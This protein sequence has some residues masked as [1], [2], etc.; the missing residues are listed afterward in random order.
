MT[1]SI[2]I[3]A[4]IR[5]SNRLSSSESSHLLNKTPPPPPPLSLSLSLS[6]LLSIVSP[7]SYPPYSTIYTTPPLV[8]LLLIDSS[9]SSPGGDSDTPSYQSS[10][11][12]YWYSTVPHLLPLYLIRSVGLLLPFPF[13]SCRLH[14]PPL[15]HIGSQ[16]HL[17]TLILLVVEDAVAGSQE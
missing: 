12:P 4:S 13:V 16:H 10:A 5:H 8:S 17:D 6:P 1:Y 3:R 7:C 11:S 9:P 15:L 2:I 14:L